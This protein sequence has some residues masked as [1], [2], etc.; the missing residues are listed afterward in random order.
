MIV[1]S[2]DLRAVHLVALERGE[3]VIET[4]LEFATERNIRCASVNGIGAIDGVEIGAFVVGERRYQKTSL[5]GEWELLSLNGNLADDDDGAT[6][7]HPHVVLGDAEGHT[8][9]GHLFAASCAVTVELVI[10]EYEGTLTRRPD[11]FTG[12]KLWS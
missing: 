6:V 12:L 4:L 7:F 8:R 3:P 5:P 9:G 2:T 10:H 11:E 1:H